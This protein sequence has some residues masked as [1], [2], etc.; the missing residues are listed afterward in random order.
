MYKLIHIYKNKDVFKPG[1]RAPLNVVMFRIDRSTA[2]P[3]GPGRRHHPT[4]ETMS[5]QR[6]DKGFAR[7][8]ETSPQLW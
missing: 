4:G 1:S 2:V 6:T 3:P 5:T 8:C 7:K